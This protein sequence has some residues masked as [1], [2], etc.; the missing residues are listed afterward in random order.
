MSHADVFVCDDDQQQEARSSFRNM[1]AGGDE[2]SLLVGLL[3]ACQFQ[4][5]PQ[6]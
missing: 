6:H 3:S 5:N 4:S 2:L 1:C